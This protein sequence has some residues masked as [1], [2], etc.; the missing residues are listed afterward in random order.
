MTILV[1]GKTGQ[2]GRELSALD[3][4][5][6][7]SRS[8]ANFLEIE[9]CIEKIDLLKPSAVI[10]A[11]AYTS[12][13]E[14]EKSEELARKINSEAP[15]HIARI[16]A[17]VGI[18][19]VHISTDYVFDGSGDSGWHPHDEPRPISIYGQSKLE[20]E[21]QV[22]QAGG[23]YVILRTS[24]VFSGRGNNFVNKIVEV[25][26]NKDKISVSNDQVGGPTDARDLALAA[27]SIAKTLRAM[28]SKSGVYHFSGAPDISRADFARVILKLANLKTK[29]ID[30]PTRKHPNYAERPL[31]SRLNCDSLSTFNLERP[32]WQLALMS[33]LSKTK[34]R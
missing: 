19:F 3:D 30:V 9:S 4:V 26:R 1:F 18:P 11:A 21:A 31:N 13:D 14:A 5:V 2:V 15:G 29:V 25:S 20:G 23:S 12:V 27:Y 33:T 10:N 34:I 24:W 17:K 28:P 32:N 22:I 16:C 7:L 6:S 8:D